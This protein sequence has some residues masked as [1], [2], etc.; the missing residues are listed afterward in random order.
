[1]GFNINSHRELSQVTTLE[2]SALDIMKWGITNSFPQ[3][4]KNIVEQSANAKPAVERTAKFYKGAGFDGEDEV[5]NQLGMTLKDIVSHCADELALFDGFAIQVDFN[6]K[7]EIVSMTPLSL[8]DLRYKRIDTNY[9][10]SMIGYHPNFGLN[11]DV[12]RTVTT[13]PTKENIKFI[14]RFNPNNV[15]DQIEKYTLGKYN[16]QILYYSGSGYSSYPVPQLQAPINFVLSDVENSILVRKETSTGFIN[17]YLLKTMLEKESPVLEAIESAIESAQGARG[18]GKVI[19]LSGLSP[20]EMNGTILEEIQSGGADGTVIKSAKLTYD[21]DRE[22]IVGA[23][24]IPPVLAGI[25]ISKGFSQNDLQEAY[26]V[27]N[28]ITQEG[29]DIIEQHVNRLLKYSRFKVK[30]IKIKKLTLD[31]DEEN[32][33]GDNNK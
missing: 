11:D 28:S 25:D 16:G 15:I 29:R 13:A 20:E 19:T 21:L 4:L 23:Y 32:I 27:F 5:V 24:L 22:V 14:H 2:D 33:E 6:L 3:T 10:S 17:T 12:K 18:Q 30:N 9:Y 8:T 7:G 26:F 1:M 31:V